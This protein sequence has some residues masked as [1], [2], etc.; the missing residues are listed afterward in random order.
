MEE[1]EY[2]KLTQREHVYELPDS[3]VGSIDLEKT[4]ALVASPGSERPV[5][6]EIE[7]VPALFKVYDEILVNAI[8]QH[9]RMQQ[10]DQ[11][12][13]VGRITIWVTDNEITVQN[14]GEG[15][16]IKT[17]AKYEG[18]Y[19]PELIFGHLLTSSNYDRKGKVTGGKNGFG[20]KLANI[21][22][23][24]FVVETHWRDKSYR[25]SFHENM[26]IRDPPLVGPREEG[27]SGTLIRFRPDLARFGL[28]GISRD[29]VDLFRR[30][31]W[32]T[33]AWCEDV[34]VFFNDLP[35]PVRDFSRYC[36]VISEENPVVHHRVN[37]NWEIA[38]STNDNEIF[39]HLSLVNGINTQKGGTHINAVAAQ[40]CNHVASNLSKKHKTKIKPIYVKNQLRV[41]VRCTI[42]NPS[43]AS[44]T[45]VLLTTN[46]QKFGSRCIIPL[47]FIR[48]LLDETELEARVMRMVSYKEGR[49][50]RRTDGK[51]TNKIKGI[52]KLCDAN[53]AGGRLSHRC[54]LIL[55]EGDSAKTMAIAGLS[56]IGR[57]FY[58]VYPL[59]G[60]LL[61]VKDADTAKISRNSEICDLKKILGL[62]EREQ[63]SERYLQRGKAW[64]LRYGKI[65]IMTDQDVDGSHIK[66]LLLNLFH[67]GWK[68]LLERGDFVSALLTPIVKATRRGTRVTESFYTLQDYAKW[69]ATRD[70]GQWTAKYYKGLGTST[71]E[72]AKSYFRDMKLVSYTWDGD[73]D[74]AMGLAFDKSRS[75]DRKEWLLGYESNP[76]PPQRDA[77]AAPEGQGRTRMRIADFVN[78]ELIH[79]SHYNVLRSIPSAVDGLKPSQ[80]KIL[81]C[82]FHKLRNF[83]EMKVAQLAGHVAENA[84][85]HHGENSLQD[86]IVGLAQDFVGSNNFPLLLPRGTFGSRLHGGR[87]AAS[88]RYIYT[89]LNDLTPLLF[90]EADR[91]LVPQQWDDGTQIEPEYFCPI[92]PMVLVNGA[93][94]IGTGFST[95]IPMHKPEDLIRSIRKHLKG[96]LIDPLVPWYKGWTGKIERTKDS[97]TMEGRYEIIDPETVL[98]VELPPGTWT[99]K[100]KEYLEKLVEK[101]KLRNYID[102]SSPEEVRITLQFSSPPD[103][104][105]S[106]LKLRTR[107]HFTN[108]YLIGSDGRIK[109]YH[110]TREI[111]RD[112]CR[113]R[114][115]VYEKRRLAGIS[116]LDATVATNREKIR[117]VKLVV[118]G[119]LDL[120]SSQRAIEEFL[121]DHQFSRIN[122][123]H[124]HLLN[125]KLSVL[126]E[127]NVRQLEARMAD[128]EKEKSRLSNLTAEKMWLR[129]L[130]VLELKLITQGKEGKEGK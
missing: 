106:V 64:P 88:A 9:T 66:G 91:R 59:R 29:M 26:K 72:E 16:P 3:Y 81:H 13:R 122:G 108:M 78:K 11:G 128:L 14:D 116:E 2:K 21:F 123:S 56:E 52:P 79:Y 129:E 104:L 24:E 67:T 65:I 62:K 97:Y 49:V 107:K 8:D 127:E 46:P 39:E 47:E 70:P 18:I 98:V 60:K 96:I 57:D 34:E 92:I 15:I 111:V 71:P 58:G 126:N 44:Q 95:F 17:M 68:G 99:E 80:R 119:D 19:I 1:D 75:D 110:D 42:V 36:E 10:E 40:I 102:H 35:I 105:G 94:G 121:D 69:K 33:A 43:F 31:A 84:C 51:K 120:R 124:N 86:A 101:K 28:P 41:F 6:K 63:Y 76:A 23:H 109:K 77:P 117:F 125:L 48:R 27:Q 83:E 50:L 74:D 38:A 130:E 37:K 55:T 85:Y 20:A 53:K 22:S 61:N 118:D 32:D 103:D 90:P 89:Q 114:L 87:D 73:A 82:V 25:Q 12:R 100:Y 45:K 113:V 112:F 93:C 115:G 30:R 4:S 7:Y 5:Q 54:A